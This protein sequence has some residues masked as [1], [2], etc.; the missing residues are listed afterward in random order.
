MP[1]AAPSTAV[2]AASYQP[3]QPSFQQPCYRKVCQ[4]TAPHPHH[5]Q[6]QMANRSFSSTLWRRRHHHHR[7]A[8]QSF[9]TGTARSQWKTQQSRS[10]TNQNGGLTPSQT[11][12]M[13][14]AQAIVADQIQ[15]SFSTQENKPSPPATTALTPLPGLCSNFN[16]MELTSKKN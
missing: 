8:Y 7:R 14:K 15:K 4:G 5:P 9:K 1:M 11:L 13:I 12:Q 10:P 2:A 16:K 6:T 3:P